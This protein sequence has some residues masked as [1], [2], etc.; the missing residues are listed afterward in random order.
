MP[1]PDLSSLSVEATLFDHL[2]KRGVGRDNCS[3]HVEPILNDEDEN[4]NC[5]VEGYLM[6]LNV[7]DAEPAPGSYS[8]KAIEVEA[9]GQ[10]WTLVP[11]MRRSSSSSDKV[12]RFERLHRDWTERVFPTVC[13]RGKDTGSVQWDDY[14]DDLMKF[15]EWYY[16]DDSQE[17]GHLFVSFVNNKSRRDVLGLPSVGVFASDFVYISLVCS[18][19]GSGFGKQLMAV[20]YAAAQKLGSKSIV[21]SSLSNSAGFYYSLGYTFVSKWDGTEVNVKP[22]LEL[23]TGKDGTPKLFLNRNIDHNTSSGLSKRTRGAPSESDDNTETTENVLVKK[24]TRLYKTLDSALEQARV[25]C[26]RLYKTN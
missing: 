10:S 16:L 6:A 25:M 23:R 17:R 13:Y 9:N 7:K 12:A 22:W 2:S 24:R 1:L 3:R 26:V 8:G 19:S 14:G 21:L 4:D 15:T 11:N 20:A 18:V 5:A